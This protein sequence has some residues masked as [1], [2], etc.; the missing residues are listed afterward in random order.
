MSNRDETERR[1]HWAEELD[2]AY[3]FMM[4]V[5]EYP[6]VE[7]G[8]PLVS[9]EHAATAAGVEVA[10]SSK[11]HVAGL[12]RLYLMREGQ[13]P[14]FVAAARALNERGWVLKVEDGFR[15]RTMQKYVGRQ[16]IVFD[17]I[18]QKVIWELG[19]ELPEIDFF[20]K[21][22][23]TL[24]AQM[25][26]I[27]THM[28]GSAIDVSVLERESGVDV[29]RGGPYLEMSELTPMASPFASA[30]GQAN[31][32][33]IMAIMRRAG[34][35]EYPYE[36]WHFNSGDA[37][38]AILLQSGEPARYGPIECDPA[39]GAVT[40]FANPTAPLSELYELE[41]EVEAALQRLQ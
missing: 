19:G 26:K 14:G 23:L 16:P 30:T 2:R 1:A 39:T 7:C 34:F 20:F 21:R 27:G 36:F 37:Y 31:R 17:A 32:R 15:N 12:P 5:L 10:F 8:E 38:E 33:E 35:V 22:L 40:P 11:P 9:L 41:A 25:P 28:S 29:D 6:V 3:D 24:T 13:I 18:L 4:A